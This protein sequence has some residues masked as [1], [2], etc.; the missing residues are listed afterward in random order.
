MDWSKSLSASY[1]A[2]IVD[3][4]TWK[5]METIEIISGSISKSEDDLRESADIVVS[6]Y[7]SDKERWIRIYLDARQ[8][9][10]SYYGPIFTGLISSP[11]VELEGSVQTNTLRCYSVF[12]PARDILLPKGYYIPYGSNASVILRSLLSVIKGIP[13]VILGESKNLS[14][15]IIAENG[16][17]SLSMADKVLYSMGWRMYALGDGTIVISEP[18]T[19]P[20]AFFDSVNADSI[21][22]KLNI[23]NNWFDC[24]NVFRAAQG[25]FSAVARDEDPDSFLSIQ[26][27]GRE[28]WFEETSCTPYIGESLSQYAR[29]RLKEEQQVYMTVSYS[30][31]FDP[32]ANVS[33]VISI[34]YPGQG[35]DGLF[36]ISSQNINL[37]YSPTVSEV[38]YRI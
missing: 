34:H 22:M 25:N 1:K 12:K 18:S 2:Y 37:G 35:L 4:L 7:N 38:V 19:E 28:V 10:D 20:S 30:R 24:P 33:D 31:R 23:E 21:E 26:N 14:E 15:T 8:Q 17:S 13:V 5:D 36:Y 32:N 11:G 16:E 3:P 9:T 6:N 29:R 27:R